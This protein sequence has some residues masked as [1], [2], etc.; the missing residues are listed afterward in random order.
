MQTLADA[1]KPCLARLTACIILE[2]ETDC[3]MLHWHTP[4]GAACG[5][6]CYQGIAAPVAEQ[7]SGPIEVLLKVLIPDQM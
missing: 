6:N 4:D 3:N 7:P 5:A 2:N 1:K